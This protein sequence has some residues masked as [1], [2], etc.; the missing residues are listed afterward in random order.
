MLILGGAMPH[1][2]LAH[3]MDTRKFWWLKMGLA[4]AGKI[5]IPPTDYRKLYFL[6]WA[7]EFKKALPEANFIYV[8]GVESRATAET[9]LNEGFELF[10]IGHVLIEDPA[11]VNHMKEGGD[12]Y[13]S[14][15]KR[16]NYCVGRMYTLEMKC[17]KCV[18]N[19]PKKIQK[20]IA[21]A[22]AKNAITN[23]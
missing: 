16:S 23:K 11:F 17:H 20:E 15:C 7:K 19:L 9:V 3:Y 10:Q 1:K 14:Q 22:E 6:D 8:G 12:D 5:V 4:I 18:E 13:C 21:K 2:T